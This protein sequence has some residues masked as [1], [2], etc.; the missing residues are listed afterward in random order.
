MAPEWTDLHAR[1]HRT[2]R[3]RQLFTK[4]DRL[5]VAVSGGQDS[6]CLIRLLLDLQPKWQ[7]NIAIA[8]CNHRWAPD[9]DRVAA[10]MA[11]WAEQWQ[12]PFYGLTAAEIDDREGSARQWRYQALLQVAIAHG[13]AAIVTAHTASDRAETLIHNLV[14]GSGADG[15]Q[16][17]SWT[18]HLHPTVHLVRP[19]LDVTRDQTAAFCHHRT[20]AVYDDPFNYDRRYARSRIRHDV[21]PY[22]QRH[23]NPHVEQALNQTVEILQAEVDYLETQTQTLWQQATMP[24]SS[25]DAAPQLRLNRLV[26]QS[27]P[28]ALQRRVIRRWLYQILPAAPT[29]AHIEKLT[30]LITAAQ[31]TQTDPFPGGAIAR[32]DH[33]WIVMTNA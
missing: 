21:L 27:A 32:V 6:V 2:I 28:L 12:V 3:Q 25:A 14:R 9:E 26:L 19:L 10:H 18:R 30:A 33:E 15:L 31:R 7:W 23:L 4:S 20:L 13:Y 1:L 22:L 17:L 5:L 11:V 8:H 24:P 16:S 29:F